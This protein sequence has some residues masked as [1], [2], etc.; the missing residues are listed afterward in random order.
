MLPENSVRYINV[1][2]RYICCLKIKQHIT[3]IHSREYVVEEYIVL[4][5]YMSFNLQKKIYV[6]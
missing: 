4:E 5:N 3:K 1:T 2:S 6:V